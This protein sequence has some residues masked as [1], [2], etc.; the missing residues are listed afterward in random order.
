MTRHI[1][2]QTVNN[3]NLNRTEHD[4]FIQLP[5]VKELSENFSRLLR[6]TG[7]QIVY[8]IPK[9][10]N[11]LIRRAKDKLPT[12]EKTGVVYKINCANCSSSYIGQTKR[13]LGTRIKEHFNNIKVHKSNYSVISNH[14]LDNGHDFAWDTP[15]ILHQEKYVRKRE[16]AE[17][18]YIK[19][20]ENTINLQ[21]DT[22]NLNNVYDK[23]IKV[24]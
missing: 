10:L 22:D 13:Q 8:C 3:D 7:L 14:K 11:T 24:V 12:E 19:K 20:F 2:D 1:D 6:D 21:K 23:L 17:M 5:F 4:R 15:L 16:I 9:K 18:F